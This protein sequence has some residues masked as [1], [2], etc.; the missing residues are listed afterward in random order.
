MIMKGFQSSGNDGMFHVAVSG[1]NGRRQELQKIL[2]G[3][4][5]LSFNL[6]QSTM[7]VAIVILVTAR[8]FPP[9]SAESRRAF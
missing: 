3:A 2:G 5:V 8:R 1:L 9:P 4:L 7:I 6:L